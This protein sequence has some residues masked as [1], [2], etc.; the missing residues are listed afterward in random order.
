MD[1]VLQTHT[2]ESPLEL[3][4]VEPFA[5][6]A[7][8]SCRLLVRSGGFAGSMLFC[9]EADALERFLADLDKMDRTLS[10][11]AR[12]AEERE[13]GFVDLAMSRAGQVSVSGEVFEDGQRLLFAFGADQTCLRPLIRDLQASTRSA[14]I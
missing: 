7:G 2:I 6:G 5:V 4:N 3:R 8:Y 10:G 11:S 9:F 12:L 14:A 13:P 1:V